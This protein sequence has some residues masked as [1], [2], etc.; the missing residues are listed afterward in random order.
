[1][2]AIELWGGAECTINRIG[3]RYSNQLERTGHWQR[4]DEDLTRFAALGLRKLRFP[5]LWETIAP[6]APEECDWSWTDARLERLQELGLRPIAGLLHHGSGPRYTSLVDPEFPRKFAAFAARVARRYPWI[7]AYTPINEPLTTARFSG[8]YGYWFPH[9]RDEATFVRAL[10]NQCR[11]IALAMAEIRKV[12]PSAL[13]MQTDDLGRTFST[14]KLRHQAIFDNERRWL[15]WDLLSGMVRP[16]HI[17]WQHLLEAGASRQEL[18]SLG[19]NPAPPD[20]IGINHYVTSDRF[21][22]EKIEHYPP[23]THGGNRGEA[24]ADDA[25]VRACSTTSGFAGAIRD[26]QARYHKPIALTEVHLGST[27]DEQLRW[28]MEAW[29]AAREGRAKG[30]DVRAITAWSLLGS[31]DWD[32]LVTQPNEHYEPGVFDLSDGEVRS[33]ILTKAISALAG[34]ECADDPAL[35]TRGWWR[36]PNRF[37][38]REQ[39]RDGA[40]LT[41]LPN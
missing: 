1:M 18:D 37:R 17:M 21:L 3:G 10:L 12:N 36:Q 24:Y 13:L 19:E 8:L 28:L 41:S 30:A 29:E 23:E 25:A 15:G 35:A 14:P 34:G 4:A 6:R 11:G 20:V 16:G 33:T 26:A 31:F 40:V 2:D 5:I 27:P 39:A 7:D 32:S 22:D 9:G 38:R